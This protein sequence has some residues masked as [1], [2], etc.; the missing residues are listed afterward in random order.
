[1]QNAVTDKAD[2]MSQGEKSQQELGQR[3]S[4]LVSGIQTV[5]VEKVENEPE[6]QKPIWGTFHFIAKPDESMAA[7]THGFRALSPVVD[8]LKIPHEVME[9]IY[10]GKN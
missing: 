7:N 5:S 8:A 10:G 4:S 3:S 9:D 6:K 1:M 2:V